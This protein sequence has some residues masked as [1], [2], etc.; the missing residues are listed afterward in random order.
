MIDAHEGHPSDEEKLR[1][2]GKKNEGEGGKQANQR[3]RRCR[4]TITITNLWRMKRSAEMDEMNSREICLSNPLGFVPLY[5]WGSF[6][7]LL[8]GI[9]TSAGNR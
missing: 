9:G 1:K 5:F 2:K 8:P 4:I 6:L 7:F 3:E